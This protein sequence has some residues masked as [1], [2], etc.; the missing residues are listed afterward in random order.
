MDNLA[1][2]QDSICRSSGKPYTLEDWK[3]R[4]IVTNI[5]NL[6]ILQAEFLLDAVV[7]IKLIVEILMKFSDTELL[8]PP[9]N[10]AGDPSRDNADRDA[11]SLEFDDPVSI[12]NIEFLELFSLAGIV[13]ASVGHDAVDVKKE[14]PNPAKR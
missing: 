10:D 12:F 1:H 3:I 14:K 2:I 13:Q 9:H 7:C 6:R 8:S 11:E 5:S 4:L